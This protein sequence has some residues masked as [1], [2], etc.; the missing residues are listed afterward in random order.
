MSDDRFWEGVVVGF[1]C[2]AW[3]LLMGYLGEVV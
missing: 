3:M 1:I 2:L